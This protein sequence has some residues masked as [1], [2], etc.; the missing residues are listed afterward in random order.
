[1]V[2]QN[3][4]YSRRKS[5]L[6]RLTVKDTHG[7]QE[8]S[9][10]TGELIEWEMLVLPSS[11]ISAKTIK[12]QYNKR[13]K[14]HLTRA[15]VNDILPEIAELKRNTQYVKAVEVDGKY[16]ILEGVRRTT[17]VSYVPDGKLYMLVAKSLNEEE[18]RHYAQMSD[19][20][21][22]PTQLDIGYSALEIREQY[23]QQNDV[24]RDF[25]LAEMFGVSTG[26]MSE[27]I[28]SASLPDSLIYLFPALEFIQVRFLRQIIAW[29]KVNELA[30][31]EEII[32]LFE[33]LPEDDKNI[34]RESVSLQKKILK[35]LAA[36][37][38]KEIEY[39]P[40]AGLF[41]HI[42]VIDGIGL[43]VKPTGEVLLTI[44]TNDL[45]DE[46]LMS[47]RELI[48]KLS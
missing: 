40:A 11:E 19:V 10:I 42:D 28:T 21:R 43:S 38:A 16:E 24:I 23:K 33:Q 26:K 45:S 17:A 29:I 32:K 14:K 35:R 27:A 41:A 20:Y 7:L 31:F 5:T 1:M 18:K 6:P 9:P 46:Y 47:I 48:S 3:T 37:V 2:D 39:S 22:E 4:P 15:A 13:S 25:K 44:D 30:K 36:S 12:S 8:P 34:Q